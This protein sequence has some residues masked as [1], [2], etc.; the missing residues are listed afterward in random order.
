MWKPTPEEKDRLLEILEKHGGHRTNAARELGIPRT[1]LSSRLEAVGIGSKFA[2]TLAT[3]TPTH[4]ETK[5]CDEGIRITAQ[6]H[7]KTL[8]E[9]LDAAKVDLN[10]W[11]VKSWKANAWTTQSSEGPI[12]AHQVTAHLN[13]TNPLGLQPV[14]P[15]KHLPRREVPPKG[16]TTRVER[17]LFVP[18]SQNGYMWDDTRTR[19][20]P[21]HDRRA[22][23]ICLQAARYFQPD[24]IHFLGDMADLAIFSKKFIRKPKYRNTTGPTLHE[25]HWWLGQF[26]LA[27]PHAIL[28]YHDGNH[29][30]R[31]DDWVAS[32]LP[33]LH[34]VLK[35]GGFVPVLSLRNLLNLDSLHV[36]YVEPINKP[37]W[38]WKQV[39]ILH[40][41]IVSKGG[42]ATVARVLKEK[43][44]YSYVFGHIHRRELAYRTIHGPEGIVEIFAMS[45]G[46]ICRLD[47]VVPAYKPENDWQQGFALIERN[48]DVIDASLGTIKNGQ[49]KINGHSFIG[50]HRINEIVDATGIK[51]LRSTT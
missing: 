28:R 13:R 47:D 23:D 44:Q 40:G 12:Q 17:A 51:Q 43:D 34:G 45:P 19:L 29:E 15:V 37:S 24:H 41:D 4:I 27:C 1:T 10:V 33:E 39:K 38:L 32:D 42:G 35:P 30:K 31:M 36:E 14:Q 20:I 9:L 3:T 7:I 50:S 8:E 21:F 18:D 16:Q 11:Y 6:G 25:L 26:R 2:T 49:G 46:C 22:W 5:R 48:G